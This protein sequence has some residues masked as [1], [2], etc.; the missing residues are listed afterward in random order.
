MTDTSDLKATFSKL[1]LQLWEL[2]MQG[3]TAVDLAVRD[4]LDDD[5]EHPIS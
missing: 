2:F 4:S 5:G 3:V 1:F